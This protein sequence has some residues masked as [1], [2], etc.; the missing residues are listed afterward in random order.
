MKR[1]LLVLL[2]FLPLAPIAQAAPDSP[3]PLT[4]ETELDPLAFCADDILIDM[5]VS[6]TGH[7][8]WL[9]LCKAGAVGEEDDGYILFRLTP[10]GT[11]LWGAVS[12]PAQIDTNSYI[13]TSVDVDPAGRAWVWYTVNGA[14]TYLDVW[15][16]NGT[17]AWDNIEDFENAMGI[18]RTTFEEV[19][20]TTF[21]AYSG[22]PA[23]RVGQ[24]CTT[25]QECEVIFE[26]VGNP[27]I[28]NTYYAGPYHD[29]LY[30]EDSNN[31]A[32]VHEISIVNKATGA[33]TITNTYG[34]F[35]NDGNGKVWFNGP[36]DLVALPYGRATSPVT[37]RYAE[38]NKTTLVN[39][40]DIQPIESIVFGYDKNFPDDAFVDGA[41]GVF[42][43]GIA[44]TDGVV[45]DSFI[46]KFNS[47]VNMGM[48]WNITINKQTTTLFERAW[49]CALG[50][51]GSLFV[52]LRAC[53]ASAENCQNFARK[54]VG[55][56]TPLDEQDIFEQFSD[57]SSTTTTPPF[58]Q[59]GGA[60]GFK[61]FCLAVGFED[62]AGRFLCGLI[63]VL[64]GSG[65][66]A[67]ALA[68]KKENGAPRFGKGSVFGGGTTFAGLAIFV[69]GIEL[70]PLYT[71]VIMIAAVAFF[72]GY[73]VKRQFA[74]G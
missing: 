37:P 26:L 58:G 38:Y 21:N 57:V 19:N 31:G 23:A 46:S 20:E 74:G 55:A 12:V 72:I 25:S 44:F 47:T 27:G 71:L 22:G 32:S 35:P 1:S 4:W 63:I 39:V 36:N 16:T 13:P 50:S 9:V 24:S 14:L 43:C 6:E 30:G 5:A 69:T 7:T 73:L 49:A 67:Y 51:D 8:Y 48:R 17:K 60:I 68:D 45:R 59:G 10:G 66:M 56:G 34:S 33:L 3:P 29:A 42:Y 2:L 54:Y 41:G 65:I 11:L 62:T 15:G 70:W 61:D 18:T 28:E 40:R 52:G 64:T 53:D